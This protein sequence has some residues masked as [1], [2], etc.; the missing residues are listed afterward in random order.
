M[1][2]PSIRPPLPRRTRPAVPAR[3]ARV[4]LAALLLSFGPACPRPALQA[5]Q[6]AATP[7]PARHAGPA[8]REW[9]PEAF[10]EAKAA[11][12]VVLIDVVAV[13]CHWCHVMDE[14]TYADPE[15]AALLAEHFVAIRVDS[16]ARP[17]VGERYADWGW[18][19]TAILTRDARP[20]LELRGY[21]D[22]REF[23]AL[24]RRLADDNAAGRLTGRIPAPARPPRGGDLKALRE[25]AQ[26]QLDATWHEEQAGW[27]RK[28][29]YPLAG[30]NEYSLLR[31]FLGQD[32]RWQERA[33]LV[34]DRQRALID[35]VWGG[36]YQY[37]VGGVWTDPHFEKI[38]AIQ[39]GALE[40]YALAFRRT[41]DP[42]WRAAAED[43]R[44]YVLGPLQDPAGGFYTSQDADLRPKTG[45]PVLGADYYARGDA[46]RRALGT[47]AIDAH[48]YADLNGL[49]IRG[50]A[51][52]AAALGD[53][54]AA[55][56]AR[57]A[58]ERLLRTHAAPGGAFRHAEGD[59]GLLYLRDQVH[60]GRA[61]LALY[62]LTGD[63]AWLTRARAL[64]DFLL[65][66]LQ[67]PAGGFFAH[68]QDPAAVGVFAERRRPF[69][70]NAAAARFLLEL[71][72]QLDH[73]AEGLP[74]APAAERTLRTI[75]APDMV[76]GQGRVL[77]EYL[78]ALAE[79]AATPVDITVVGRND[80]PAALALLRAALAYDEPRA[81]LSL[82]PPGARYPDQGKPA[83]YLCTDTACSTPI[84][85]P[86]RFAAAA[87][88][89]LRTIPRP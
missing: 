33:L 36:M 52:V 14:E 34:L 55:A 20:V 10:A 49:L 89:F 82:S 24:L 5:P 1:P 72:R 61:L 60:V 26:A 74:Y 78:S 69:D 23:A 51:Q 79:L 29:K 66:E 75:S 56:A 39:A 3:A 68:T 42:R 4:A 11:G 22:P 53:D 15:V 59:A 83:A 6:A 30:N 7:A 17:D 2:T 86:A 8:W 50:L 54:D 88:A 16:D 19:A 31:A 38:A 85:D 18:P 41:R 47:P 21:Q 28:Q 73:D 81:A 40:S 45:E 58:G 77:G 76:Q 64:A 27:G 25:A 67:D 46:E 57:R 9:G 48:V 13:W 80:Q 63:P 70:E 43:I 84:T 62:R 44:R 65:R 35:P 71:H 32:P 37:S 87:D 12:K